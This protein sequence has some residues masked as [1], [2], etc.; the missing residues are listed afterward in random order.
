MP[1]LN[2]EARGLLA[3]R[4]PGPAP[5]GIGLVNPMK[6]VILAAGQ[7]HRLWPFT[8]DRPKCLLTVGRTTILEQQLQHLE[9]VGIDE[10][11]LVCGFGV[12][13]ISAALT[14]RSSHLRVKLLYNPFYAVSDNLISLWVA[15]SEMDQDFILLNGDNVFHPGI[16]ERLLEVDDICCLM[17]DSRVVYDED[18]M[19]VQLRGDRVLQIGK[20][21]SRAVTD[22]ESVGIMRFSGAGVELI[23]RM[24]EEIVLDDTA[25]RSYFPD[26]VQRLVAQGYPVVWRDVDGLPWADVDTPDDLREVRRRA[27][28]YQVDPLASPEAGAYR[29]AK[30]SA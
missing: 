2:G 18:A 9:R 8:A 25:L 3:G 28:V 26:S 4:R 23:R 1:C 30:G 5:V 6:A 7:G 17:G 22:A 27:H 16:A 29:L 24:L 20:G 12:D 11:V 15:R 10:V 19:K 21:L 14:D 13:R